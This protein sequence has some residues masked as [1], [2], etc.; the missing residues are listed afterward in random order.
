MSPVSPLSPFPKGTPFDQSPDVL[1]ALKYNV[2]V[3]ISKKLHP[4]VC[5]SYN[6]LCAVNPEELTV[7]LSPLSP[8]EPCGITKVNLPSVGL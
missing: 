4:T 6:A 1:L 5:A 8:F 3:V 2:D 7:K